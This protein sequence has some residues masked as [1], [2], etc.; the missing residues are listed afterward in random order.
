MIRNHI[1]TADTA[2]AL[3]A[4]GFPQGNGDIGA[5]YYDDEHRL[6]TL[7]AN[8][9]GLFTAHLFGKNAIIPIYD[10]ALHN[11]CA[12]APLASELTAEL[13]YGTEESTEEHDANVKFWQPIFYR[14]NVAEELAGV[15]LKHPHKRKVKNP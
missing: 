7:T 2:F 5:F 14:Y 3:K 12:R 13:L 6:L 11:L 9:S 10:Y 1:P 4:A 8:N 15:W